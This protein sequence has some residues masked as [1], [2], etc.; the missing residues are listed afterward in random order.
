MT[1]LVERHVALLPSFVEAASTELPAAVRD[2]LRELARKVERLERALSFAEWSAANQLA[3]RDLLTRIRDGLPGDPE[4]QQAIRPQLK[5]LSTIINGVAPITHALTLVNR[6][7]E[8]TVA[9]AQKLLRTA[10]CT[11]TAAALA[12]IE[13]IGSL[14]QAQVD[15][16]RARLHGRSEYWR[17]RI[18]QG[19][20]SF[21]PVLR[22][23]GMDAKGVIEI[24]VGRGAVRA[25][26]Q[27]ITNASAL[28]ASLL[29]FFLAFR[30]HVLESNGG[31]ELLVLDDPQDLLDGDNR[32]R[33]ARS[34]AQIAGDAQIVATHA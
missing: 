12:E 11:R 18:Y 31:L 27:H 1:A 6:M 23:T 13:P 9:R 17:D 34:I 22:E 15:G 2:R 14:A 24:K 28:R 4:E 33:L 7:R 10:S 21:A 3:I 29:A 30:E 25:P 32:Q 16:L 8:S 5:R 19:A 26:A 20:T